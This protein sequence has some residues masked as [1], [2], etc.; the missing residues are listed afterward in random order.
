[1]Y[2]VKRSLCVLGTAY[3]AVCIQGLRVDGSGS[4]EELLLEGSGEGEALSLADGGHGRSA[5]LYG[6]T[7]I[8]AICIFFE[9]AFVIQVHPCNCIPKASR[10]CL[11]QLQVFFVALMLDMS[12][13]IIIRI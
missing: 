13:G 3:I 7:S 1:M 10:I 2:V 9:L 6:A 12:T 5:T 11:R 4:I 8:I